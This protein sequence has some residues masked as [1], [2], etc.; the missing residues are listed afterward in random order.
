[1][2]GDI[3]EVI[4]PK[5]GELQCTTQLCEGRV[6]TLGGIPLLGIAGKNHGAERVRVWVVASSLPPWSLQ[7]LGTTPTPV[8][9]GRVSETEPFICLVFKSEGR[10]P[11]FVACFPSHEAAAH[12]VRTK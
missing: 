5:H 4:H 12:S 11:E 2:T 6:S 8:T 3:C 10:P 9:L 1:V 7:T